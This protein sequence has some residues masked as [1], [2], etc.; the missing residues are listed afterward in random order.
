MKDDWEICDCQCSMLAISARS[1]VG[2]K[3]QATDWPLVHV[4]RRHSCRPIAGR[5]TVH[6]VCTHLQQT[7]QQASLARWPTLPQST[8]AESTNRPVAGHS[9]EAM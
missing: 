2:W 1:A 6:K 8:G 7:C 4:G 3:E 5:S 9:A